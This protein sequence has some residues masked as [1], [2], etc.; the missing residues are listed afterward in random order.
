MTV[1][2]TLRIKICSGKI[3]IGGLQIK[4]RNSMKVQNGD[5]R[6]FN[7]H[8]THSKTLN[9]SVLSKLFKTS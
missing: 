6:S 5:S 9:C 4:T 3:E 8:S 7:Q 1:D 2:Y